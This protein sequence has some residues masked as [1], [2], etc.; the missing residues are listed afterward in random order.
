[1]FAIIQFF[2]I[3]TIAVIF[4]LSFCCLRSFRYTNLCPQ[5]PSQVLRGLPLVAYAHREGCCRH[6]LAADS[7]PG[8]AFRF[9]SHNVVFLI[10]YNA[11]YLFLLPIMIQRIQSVYLLLA[12]ISS[13]LI[14]VFPP[15]TATSAPLSSELPVVVSKQ[16][17]TAS[18][19]GLFLSIMVLIIT[20]FM[21]NRRPLQVRLIS[22]S[23]I[24]LFVC[25]IFESFSIVQ[26][27]P[28]GILYSY[29]FHLIFPFLAFVFSVLARK[30][31]LRD[32]RL[33]RSA[34][35]IR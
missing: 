19:I 16:L 26:D 15:I 14:Y 30:A 5:L 23:V 28:N 9:N 11:E 6:Q 1:M 29:S 17:E 10:G 7:K 18:S 2:F 22:T 33:V 8:R 20:I 3:L 34:D 25:I 35:R 27:A 21:Y 12:A 31:I 13:S 24:L 4:Y 32:E